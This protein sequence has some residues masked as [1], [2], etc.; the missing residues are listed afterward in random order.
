VYRRFEAR[1]V[2]LLIRHGREIPLLAAGI[3]GTPMSSMDLLF[4]PRPFNGQALNAKV[5]ATVELSLP[6]NLRYLE[7]HI[8]A[9]LQMV[10]VAD[11]LYTLGS[12]VKAQGAH[13][14]AELSYSRL[15]MWLATVDGDQTVR[16]QAALN[17]VQVALWNLGKSRFGTH[18]AAPSPTCET[19]L[20][21][22]AASG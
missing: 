11:S 15:L 19:A 5:R 7:L 16:N 3:G 12:R 10:A 6:A 14:E 2:I 18:T 17:Q 20:F 21:Y 22:T 8:E 13:V 1:S 9:V 4:L